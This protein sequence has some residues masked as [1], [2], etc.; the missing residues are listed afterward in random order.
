M[1]IT[2]HKSVQTLTNYQHTQDKKK[3]KMGV[4][5]HQSM[6]RQED[7]INIAK[8]PQIEPPPPVNAIEYT[9]QQSTMA[10][11]PRQNVIQQNA[12]I[13]FEPN[14]DDNG[15]SDMDILSAICGVPEVTTSTVTNTT[16]TSNVLNTIPKAMFA[17]CQIGSIN[18]TFGKK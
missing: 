15:I 1:S 8:N 17:N 2:G 5:I 6:T 12:V 18:I 9:P 11:T 13:P 16:N 4:V 7:Q 14:F 10:V 3:I